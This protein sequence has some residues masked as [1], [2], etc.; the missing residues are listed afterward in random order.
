MAEGDIDQRAG[1]IDAA[2][3]RGRYAGIVGVH[4]GRGAVA[5]EHQIV[6]GRTG[7]H[8]AVDPAGQA[9]V[10]RDR[11]GP[12]L[13]RQSGEGDRETDLSGCDPR[14]P[15]VLL[16][17]CGAMDE[18]QRRH[19]HGSREGQGSSSETKGLGGHRGVQHAQAGTTETF[20]YK[21]AGQAQFDD[22]L[23]QVLIEPVGGFGERPQAIHRQTVFQEGAQRVIELALFQSERKFHQRIPAVNF[24]SRGRS[25]PRSPMMFF[26]M[27]FDPPPIIR[28][29]SYM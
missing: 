13:S 4:H 3:E 21:Q 11:C 28:P 8:H 22:A 25:N 27:L 5:S 2:A 20:R 19:R 17:L 9:T 7:I 24:G 1:A 29:T 10:H 12:G 23:P 14:Q 15:L 6:G 26:W 16:C 18:R